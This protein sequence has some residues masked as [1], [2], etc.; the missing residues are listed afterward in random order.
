MPFS[1]FGIDNRMNFDFTN[2]SEDV[3]IGIDLLAHTI[4]EKIITNAR[5]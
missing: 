4:E 1:Y 3:R 2:S 5:L